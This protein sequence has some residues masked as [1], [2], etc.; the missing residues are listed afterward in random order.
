M[1]STCL[2]CSGMED[3]IIGYEEVVKLDTKEILNSESLC[4]IGSIIHKDWL[5]EDE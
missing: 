4:S 3:C 5:I 1:I 2:T